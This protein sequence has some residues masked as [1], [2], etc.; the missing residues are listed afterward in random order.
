MNSE[1]SLDNL[2]QAPHNLEAEMSVLGAM[3]LD[4]NL[5]SQVIDQVAPEGFYKKAHRAIFSAIVSLYDSNQSVDLVT[6][7]ESLKSAGTLEDAGGA[8]YLT[9][10]IN[11]LPTTAHLDSYLKIVAGKAILRRLISTATSIVQDCYQDTASSPQLLDEVEKKVFQITQQRSQ[12]NIVPMRALVKEAMERAERL[13][14]SGGAIT[15]I[16]TGFRDLDVLTCGLQDA[17]L[18]VLAG[19]PSMGK[20]ALALNIAERA[21]LKDKKGVG[22]FSLEMSR[23]QLVFRMI[24]SHARVNAQNLRRGFL[25]NQGWARLAQ[26]ASTLSEAPIY[27]D[28]APSLG[29]LELRARA[30]SLKARYDIKLLIVDYLQLMQAPLGR[31]ESR[32]QEVSSISRAMKSLAR[33]LKLPV[34]VLSQ[35]NRE[36]ESRENRKPRLSDLRESGAIEQDADLVMLIMRP[37][38]YPDLIE[39]HPNLEKIVFVNIAKQRNGPTGEKKLIFLPEFTRFED[40]TEQEDVYDIQEEK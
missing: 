15:G 1:Q 18:V 16:A 40:Y 11:Y 27:I 29:P 10:L 9:T 23:D 30:R 7:T 12:A 32:Q 4:Q 21:A 24:C 33:E 8:P 22:I 2:R 6:L 19:R 25:S 17:D 28:D 31:S 13:H 14:Q 3:L 37:G 5:I 35:L 39:E 38:A 34:L 36:A 20:T 26:A